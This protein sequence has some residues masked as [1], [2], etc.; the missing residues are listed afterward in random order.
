VQDKIPSYLTKSL[1]NIDPGYSLRLRASFCI[2]LQLSAA[3]F[4]TV[5]HAEH[6]IAY[7]PSPVRLSV[8]PSHTEWLNKC[9]VE[10]FMQIDRNFESLFQG[11]SEGHVHLSFAKKW[12]TRMVQLPATAAIEY[13]AAGHFSLFSKLSAL[14]GQKCGTAS[15]GCPRTHQSYSQV[16]Y[17]Q[18]T[19]MWKHHQSLHSNRQSSGTVSEWV[20]EQFLNGTSAQ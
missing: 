20:S 11:L 6:A 7:M 9:E 17:S 18:K 5:Q 13:V 1:R 10:L 8:C 2:V 16:T 4:F 14:F 19:E 12:Q 15:L 3:I